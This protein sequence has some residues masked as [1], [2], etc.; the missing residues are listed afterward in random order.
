MRGGSVHL[1]RQIPHGPGEV[2]S[3]GRGTD[4]HRIREV[5][6]HKVHLRMHW[7]PGE[8]RHVEQHPPRVRPPPQNLG[9]G[10]RHDHRRGQGPTVCPFLEG[11]VLGGRQGCRQ[12]DAAMRFGS[13]FLRYERQPRRF[14]QQIESRLPPLTILLPTPGLCRP[15]R[16][17]DPLLREKVVAI[18][19]RQGWQGCVTSGECSLH[20]ASQILGQLSIAHG[21][22]RDHVD[23]QMEAMP[24]A[25]EQCEYR[26]PHLTRAEVQELMAV[27]G[28][29]LVEPALDLLRGAV[30]EVVHHQGAVL[31]NGKDSLESGVQ[32]RRAQHR[33]STHQSG[34]RCAQHVREGLRVLVAAIELDVQVSC[35]TSQPLFLSPPQPVR[36]L[37]GGQRELAVAGIIRTGQLRDGGWVCGSD[38][39]EPTTEGGIHHQL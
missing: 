24:A 12:S 17:Q 14:R 19:H 5:P 21:V 20:Q 27:I 36:V 34:C 31:R 25:R 2:L 35:N 15:G 37:H 30:P 8:Q 39:S 3:G 22:R 16:F 28:A 32:D 10:R 13:E 9:E 26:Q 18:G 7:F 23:I 4:H 11:L 33:M 38:H 1:P 29:Q 6:N